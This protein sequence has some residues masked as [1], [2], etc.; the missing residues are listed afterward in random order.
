MVRQRRQRDKKKEKKEAVSAQAYLENVP[1][2]PFFHTP[3]T[4]ADPR[5]CSRYPDSP[6]CGGFPFTN[7]LIGLSVTKIQDDCNI[8]IQ[9]DG[10]FGFVKAAPFQIVYRNQSC[11]K[12]E[13]PAYNI[14]QR[15]R[16]P[17]IIGSVKNADYI[18]F[19]DTNVYHID[20]KYG[21]GFVYKNLTTNLV[22]YDFNPDLYFSKI[23][24][25]RGFS[26]IRADT[27][28]VLSMQI[29]HGYN[30]QWVSNEF[31]S[32]WRNNSARESYKNNWLNAG[33]TIDGDY[34][35]PDTIWT[36]E[37]TATYVYY[38]NVN[39]T[40]IRLFLNESSSNIPLINTTP[41]I[42]KFFLTEQQI[43]NLP[44]DRIVTDRK[45]YTGMERD[46]SIFPIKIDSAYEPREYNPTGIT[47]DINGTLYVFPGFQLEIQGLFFTYF[48]GFPAPPP[49]P[50]ICRNPCKGDDMAC[51]PDNSNLE[52]LMKLI[53]KRIGEPT[54]VQIFD[55]DMEREGSQ[56]SNRTPPT[57]N[58]YLKLAVQRTEISNRLIGIENYPVDVPETL[59]KPFKQGIFAKIFK[60]IDDKKRK[61]LQTLTELLA[62]QAEQEQ[63]LIGTFHQAIE[64]ETGE[65]DDKG[66]PK[67]EMVVLPD[68]ATS[69][70]ELI[71]L[72]TQRCK[73]G[74]VNTDL[75]FRSTL[76]IENIKVLL[77]KTLQTVTD[78]Q[79]YLDYPTD[80]KS[81]EVPL[82][83]NLPKKE[84]DEF[85]LP[86]PTSDSESLKNLLQPG[87]GKF[88]YEDWT[89]KNSLHDQL[90]DALQ[91]ISMLRAVLYQRTDGK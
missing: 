5:D 90:L 88:T 47:Q 44:E 80:T 82:L 84:L 74:N 56:K 73:Q 3:T 61:K 18:R 38:T 15:S 50:A 68:V 28:I 24:D 72:L 36:L 10:D 78:I 70:R 81:V 27:K 58:E 66:K 49:P 55:E 8:G 62:W 91:V 26:V 9:F 40:T 37:T 71:I 39:T 54:T 67:R 22:D 14:S 48:N 31:S 2:T 11:R 35:E 1:G 17:R 46:A 77:A 6:W 42:D 33:G 52:Q 76:E 41:I 85:G 19:A 57:L 23:V 79:D 4:P 53:L 75:Q 60:F 43:N 45:P 69:L 87:S 7:R 86:V 25:F 13:T 20:N 59:I 21:N 65:L 64:F 32:I 30:T 83:L 89:G 12:P 63:A 51:C 16:K 34:L 29:S